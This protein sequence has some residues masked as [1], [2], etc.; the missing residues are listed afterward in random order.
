MEWT[1]SCS[2]RIIC[3]QCADSRM[4]FTGNSFFS[5]CN[6]RELG[7][8]GEQIIGPSIHGRYNVKCGE[9]HPQVIL[10]TEYELLS[11]PKLLRLLNSM[12]RWHFIRVSFNYQAWN[13]DN[14]F[15]LFKLLENVFMSLWYQ[16]SLWCIHRLA[17][18]SVKFAFFFLFFI[19]LMHL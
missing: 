9:N 17:Q 10:S 16:M 6:W 3:V 18:F 14:R 12:S 7:A 2:N 5:G 13:W 8:R 19:I 11:S 4:S 15:V 1:T